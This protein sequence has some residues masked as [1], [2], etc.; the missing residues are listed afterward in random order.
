[1]FSVEEKWIKNEISKDTYDRWYTTYSTAITSCKDSI[2][3][4]SHV[5][6][7][8]FTILQKNLDLLVDLKSLYNRATITQ[9]REFVKLVFDSNLYYQDGIYRTPTMIDLLSR[10]HLLMKEKGLLLYKKKG[11]IFQSSRSVESSGRQIPA[12]KATIAIY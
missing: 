6:K 1:M 11:M 5:D 4:L 3:R 10:N 7:H 2:T 12:V 8:A 9:K